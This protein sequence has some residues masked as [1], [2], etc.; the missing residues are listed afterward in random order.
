MSRP[1]STV[2]AVF[3][4]YDNT[5]VDFQS[6]SIKAL[7]KVS[8]EIHD[9]LIDEG[10]EDIS[11]SR[12]KQVVFDTSNKLDEEG[13]VDRNTWWSSSLDSL[14]IK[15]VNRSQFYDW[16]NLYWS[17]ASQSEPFPDALQFLDYLVNK[18]Y[19]I[20][21]ITNSDGEG[22]NKKKRI[23]RFPLYNIFNIVII[24]GEDGIKPK[25]NID[26]FIIAC[27]KAGLSS[28]KCVMIGDDAVKDCLASK[29]AGY[30]AI[31][32]DRSNKVKF[33]ELYADFVTY[34]LVDLEELL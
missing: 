28:D 32:I 20:G 7:D 9:Y 12:I 10:K 21:M 22:G 17:I 8:L 4:D 15:G 25:P 3:F 6:S 16:T 29:K 34:K 31:L 1:F 2:K 14:G 23:S 18:G 33:P 11:L 26:P 27:E 5:L 19:V 30:N 13:V 24:G